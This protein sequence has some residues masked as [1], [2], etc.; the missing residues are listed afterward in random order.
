MKHCMQIVAC[1]VNFL[2]DYL[3]PNYSSAYA[4]HATFH[5]VHVTAMKK[6]MTIHSNRSAL[7][8]SLDVTHTANPQGGERV[9][10]GK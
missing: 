4:T 1:I 5:G 9:S 6:M 2:D 3:L 10:T 7:D 8:L